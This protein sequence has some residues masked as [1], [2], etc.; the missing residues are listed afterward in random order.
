MSTTEEKIVARLKRECNV[1]DDY[2]ISDSVDTWWDFYSD[3]A[4]ASS[5][6]VQYLKTKIKVLTEVQGQLRMA[7]DI[8]QGP[9]SARASQLFANVTTMLKMA[10][11]E[12]DRIDPV[13]SAADQPANAESSTLENTTQMESNCPVVQGWLA[14]RP[15]TTDRYS[16][17]KSGW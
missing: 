10:K 17:G 6:E 11:D 8:T 13:L 16:S 4:L 15:L 5:T 14:E 1:Q 9:D 3:T 7:M 2:D 12:L